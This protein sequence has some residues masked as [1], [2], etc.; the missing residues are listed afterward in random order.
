MAPPSSARAA[1]LRLVWGAVRRL[2]DGEQQ[3]RDAIGLINDRDGTNRDVAGTA[4]YSSLKRL[5]LEQLGEL[6]TDFRRRSHLPAPASRPHGPKGGRP[7]RPEPLVENVTY[8]ASRGEQEYADYLFG[9]LGFDEEKRAAFVTRQTKGL[10]M[11]THQACTAVIAPLERMVRAR[12]FTIEEHRR[13]K[14]V[15]P[16]APC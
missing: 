11:T 8:L 14:S 10:G 9:L 12:G 15:R 2:P 4:D 3:L 16:V 13:L 7:R 5:T 6:A 1:L